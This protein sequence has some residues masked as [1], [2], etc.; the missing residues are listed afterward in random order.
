MARAD[1]LRS[2]SPPPAASPAKKPRLSGPSRVVVLPI[3]VNISEKSGIATVANTAVPNKNIT[4]SASDIPHIGDIYPTRRA[5]LVRDDAPYICNI[6]REGFPHPLDVRA[7][8]FGNAKYEGRACWVK[9]GQEA[10]LQWNDHASCKVTEKD[11]EAVRCKEGWVIGD[12]ASWDRIET[13]VEEGRK[14]K[15]ANAKLIGNGTPGV[16][17]VGLESGKGKGKAA[18][19]EAAAASRRQPPRKFVRAGDETETDIGAKKK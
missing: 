18:V 5:L 13:V 6:C 12:Q 11:I 3:A 7:H 17:E 2:P 10:G 15:E 14:F 8:F 4:P 9:D 16:E 19:K 1:R